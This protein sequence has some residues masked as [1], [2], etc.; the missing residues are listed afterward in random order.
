M[1]QGFVHVRISPPPRRIAYRGFQPTSN[2]CVLPMLKHPGRPL[3]Q[4]GQQEGAS[5][6]PP[7]QSQNQGTESPFPADQTVVPNSTSWLWCLRLGGTLYQGIDMYHAGKEKGTAL[8]KT[9]ST[10]KS[11]NLPDE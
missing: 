7:K 1:E 3:A 6:S 9:R 11:S 2:P 10:V 8:E 5:S 4:C